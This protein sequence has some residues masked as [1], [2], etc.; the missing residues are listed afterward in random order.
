MSR[1]LS[2][3]TSHLQL[4]LSPFISLTTIPST[5]KPFLILPVVFAAAALAVSH[6]QAPATTLL[7]AS[8]VSVDDS[9]TALLA[10][11]PSCILGYVAL[12]SASLG[13][14]ATDLACIC[15]SSSSSSSSRK[16]RESSVVD[17]KTLLAAHHQQDSN[18]TAILG[19]GPGEV[20]LVEV[21]EA[22]KTLTSTEMVT[23]ELSLTSATAEQTSLRAARAAAPPAGTRATLALLGLG[24]VAMVAVCAL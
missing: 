6:A 17:K 15:S 18:S 2:Q 20:E 7:D 3:P 22:A 23:E 21:V 10:A 19:A 5:M 11:I 16:S 24:G 14:A 12:A 9:L 8:P 13:C 4:C 1:V